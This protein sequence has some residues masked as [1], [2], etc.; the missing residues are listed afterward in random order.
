MIEEFSIAIFLVT[1]GLRILINTIL[2]GIAI[3]DMV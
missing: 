1:I 3:T 2:D